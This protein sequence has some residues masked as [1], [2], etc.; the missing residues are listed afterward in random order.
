MLHIVTIGL[1][2]SKKVIYVTPFLMATLGVVRRQYGYVRKY[3]KAG[4]CRLRG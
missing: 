2:R 3:L 1:K 4:S